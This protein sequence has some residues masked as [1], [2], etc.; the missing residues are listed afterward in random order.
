MKCNC[1][2]SSKSKQE[3]AKQRSMDGTKTNL[4]DAVSVKINIRQKTVNQCPALRQ[5]VIQRIKSQENTSQESVI[6][7][8]LHSHLTYGRYLRRI[9]KSTR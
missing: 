3:S 4:Q 1:D 5:N 9:Y 2:V 6:Q 7:G 8:N